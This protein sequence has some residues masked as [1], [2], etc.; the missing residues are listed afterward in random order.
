MVTYI[1]VKPVNASG[2]QLF[3]YVHAD[4]KNATALTLKG[5][6]EANE[7]NEDQKRKNMLDKKL[8]ALQNEKSL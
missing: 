4:G 5:H 6:K 3:A 7:P 1:N 8:D 2:E